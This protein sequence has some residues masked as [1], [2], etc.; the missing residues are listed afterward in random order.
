[1]EYNHIKGGSRHARD[2]RLKRAELVGVGVIVI[3][4]RSQTSFVPLPL[5]GLASCAPTT[6][7]DAGHGRIMVDDPNR[8]AIHQPATS[9][10][11]AA[12][13]TVIA[14]LHAMAARSAVYSSMSGT[15]T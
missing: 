6:A 5:N 13:T 1:M 11:A 3:G 12:I 14:T 15:N 4:K 2:A 8:P 7:V 9:V 10:A